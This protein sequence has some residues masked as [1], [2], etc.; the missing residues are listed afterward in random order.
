MLRPPAAARA[1]RRGRRCGA[2]LERGLACRRRHAA[3]GHAPW[4]RSLSLL[5][6][7]LP[8]LDCAA[9]WPAL[10]RI[11]LDRCA[12]EDGDSV[13]DAGPACRELQV[14][15]CTLDQVDVSR[16]R[17]ARVLRVTNSR[18]L[19]RVEAPPSSRLRSIV[20][21]GNVALQ[22]FAL[23]HA[24][25]VDA[26]T[27]NNCANLAAW[28]PPTANDAFFTARQIVVDSCGALQVL[29]L[30]RCRGLRTLAVCRC[31][32]LRKMPLPL[33]AAGTRPADELVEPEAQDAPELCC[34]DVRDCRA[35]QD[36]D[37]STGIALRDVTVYHC[38][39]LSEIQLPVVRRH[40]E[41]GLMG[42]HRL[43][44]GSCAGLQSLRVPANCS[45]QV[46]EVCDCVHLQ[47]VE[48]AG[49]CNTDLRSLDVTRCTSLRGVVASVCGSLERMRFHHCDRLQRVVVAARFQQP[50][51]KFV[52]CPFASLHVSN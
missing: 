36:L 31:R 46:L 12:F 19:Q 5:H 20:L 50:R 33:S 1:P 48:V 4:L 11:A 42:F 3:A 25:V 6:L 26:I 44:V 35:L 39:A 43:Y 13:V 21:E 10:S 2:L 41:E 38:P 16:C 24:I 29:D 17:A 14:V 32:G 18:R 47:D 28:A 27:I 52:D 49:S 9:A 15:R 30:R 23:P 7:E 34:I 8:G 51:V 22:T 45:L 37:L 40:R